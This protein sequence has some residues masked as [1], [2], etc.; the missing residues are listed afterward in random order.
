MFHSVAP[1]CFF[2]FTL[3]SPFNRKLTFLFFTLCL[4]LRLPLPVC[5]YFLGGTEYELFED[6][7]VSCGVEA[8]IEMDALWD[9]ALLRGLVYPRAAFSEMRMFA[10][11][12][13]NLEVDGLVQHAHKSCERMVFGDG[14]PV[15][16]RVGRG[17]FEA[18]L[19]GAFMW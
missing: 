3:L 5:L 12:V 17:I 11:E 14:S 16:P 7:Y 8:V 13:H 2:F 18:N 9:F 10:S 15:G 1:L 6:R 19:L 4:P